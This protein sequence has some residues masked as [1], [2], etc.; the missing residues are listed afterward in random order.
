[1]SLSLVPA[2]FH[3]HLTPLPLSPASTPIPHNATATG[4]RFACVVAVAHAARRTPSNHRSIG[5]LALRPNLAAGAAW[6]RYALTRSFARSLIR[7]LTRSLAHSLTRSLACS[8]ARPPAR[9]PVSAC[10]PVRLRA[11]LRFHENLMHACSHAQADVRTNTRA[12][13]YALDLT[14]DHALLDK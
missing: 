6:V 5:T 11:H 2:L 8:P 13:I 3:R 14:C 4:F 12:R 9:P 10:Q 1:M 7:S